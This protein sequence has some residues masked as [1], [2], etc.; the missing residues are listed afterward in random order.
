MTVG[1][2]LL[3]GVA[4]ILMV[5]GIA[6]ILMTY[7]KAG[8]SAFLTDWSIVFILL[9]IIVAVKPWWRII[10]GVRSAEGLPEVKKKPARRIKKT[11]RK[12]K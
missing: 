3:L 7:W 10:Y 2:A 5:F 12:R 6:G 4:D 9:A 8:V 1:D 11:V